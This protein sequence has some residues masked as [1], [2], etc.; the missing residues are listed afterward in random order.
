MGQRRFFKIGQRIGQL[1]AQFLF[2]RVGRFLRREQR[3]QPLFQ[4]KNTVAFLTTGQKGG[5]QVAG[6]IGLRR[7]CSGKQG[8]GFLGL[9]ALRL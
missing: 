6:Q 7:T 5:G 8:Q 3:I 9:F 1:G 2:D 4:V